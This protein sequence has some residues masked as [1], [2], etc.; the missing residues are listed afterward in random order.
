MSTGIELQSVDRVIAYIDGFNLYF[1]LRDDA[2]DTALIISADSD[3]TTPVETVRER[4][5]QKRLVVAC[6]PRRQSKRLESAAHAY[7]RIGRKKFQDSQF[8]DAVT[9]PDGYVLKRPPSWR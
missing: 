1:G 7:L 5:P 4:F 3:L 9:K 2:F 8:P 6:P